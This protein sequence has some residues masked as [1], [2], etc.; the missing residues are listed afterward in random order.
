MFSAGLE[1]LHEI[2]FEEWG[3]GETNQN[4]FIGPNISVRRGRCFATV[5]AL[6]Q[7]THTAAEPEVQIRTVIGFAF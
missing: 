1:V 6:A 2:V 3:N 4:F 5:T 7:A